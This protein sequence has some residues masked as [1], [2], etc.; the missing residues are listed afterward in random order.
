MAT[1]NPELSAQCTVIR[2][3]LKSWEK[4][5]AR[6]NDGRKAGRADIKANAYIGAL[7]CLRQPT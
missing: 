2:V 1:A 5:F 6:A 7:L 3:E 4:D